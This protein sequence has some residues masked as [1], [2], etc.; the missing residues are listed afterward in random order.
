[1]PRFAKT[2]NSG[3]GLRGRGKLRLVPC[4]DLETT[5]SFVAKKPRFQA[6]RVVAVDFCYF[7]PAAMP[8]PRAA[9]ER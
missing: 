2:S 4:I 8:P 7:S 9:P 5:R 6:R 3:V 1:V